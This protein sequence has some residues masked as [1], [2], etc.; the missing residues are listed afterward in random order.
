MFMIAGLGNPGQQY[1]DT[2][3]NVGFWALDYLAR[4]NKLVFKETKW[5]ALVSK[6]IV[7]GESVVLLKPETFM[8]LS[9]TAVSQAAHYYKVATDHILVI[10]DDL[11]M[12]FGRLK[13]V[14]GGGD[15][16][17]KGIRSI[18][19]H[20]GTK[21][22]PRLKIGIGRPPEPVP[23]DKYVLGRFE[24]LEKETLEQR[25]SGLYEGIR[26]FLQQDIGAAMT[27]INKK[28]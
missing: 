16:G 12:E 4:E 15:G 24:P 18:V 8:N 10:H 20:L 17:H 19:Q 2:R 28:E 1:A 6:G 25:L 3:H 21:D 9:G 13:M 14:L 7:C 26:I 22:F 27:V 11:D 23:P 5:Q